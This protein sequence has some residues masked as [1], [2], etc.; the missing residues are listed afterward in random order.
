MKKS[1]LGRARSNE[2]ALASL[3]LGVLTLS[4]A[5]CAVAHEES[6]DS[7][8]R[9]TAVVSDA[10]TP[11]SYYQECTTTSYGNKRCRGETCSGK[12]AKC[13]IGGSGSSSSLSCK[14]DAAGAGA[15]YAS[16]SDGTHSCS[17]GVEC[18]KG[19]SGVTCSCQT[20][21]RALDPTPGRRAVA[22]A[23]G[24]ST[25]YALAEDGTVWA[26]GSNDR[27]ELGG[28]GPAVARPK[29]IR[30]TD[31]SAEGQHGSRPATAISAGDHGGCAILTNGRVQCWGQVVGEDPIYGSV[32]WTTPTAV[33]GVTDAVS[34]S[35][36]ASHTCVVTQS[37]SVQCWGSNFTSQIGVRPDGV[38]QEEA[39][40][41]G[42]Y[43]D[44]HSVVVGGGMRGE[45]PVGNTCVHYGEG[46]IDCY[47]PLANT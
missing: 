47:V 34:I 6:N 39:A 2:W 23:A 46:K 12:I 15:S 32:N 21:K 11:S 27:H 33:K 41:L 9:E 35:Q 26:W 4:F 45:S 7:T 14:C 1:I 18:V 29:Q 17:S 44:A 20:G 25:T 40:P 38:A 10:L 8:E 22:L 13:T 37:G 19:A 43:T 24:E 42:N 30:F 31:T 36:A 28:E 3:T 5:A 16:V